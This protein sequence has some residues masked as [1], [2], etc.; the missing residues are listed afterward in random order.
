MRVSL[1]AYWQQF[2]SRIDKAAF[3]LSTETFWGKK[4]FCKIY[5]IFINFGLSTKT[6]W[7]IRRKNFC[8]IV[9]FAFFLIG[10]IF[11]GKKCFSKA[12]FFITSSGFEQKTFRLS[13]K[14]NRQCCQYGILR[15]KRKVLRMKFFLKRFILLP[16][17]A[18]ELKKSLRFRRRKICSDFKT[19][20]FVSVEQFEDFFWNFSTF[21]FVQEFRWSSSSSM[22][23]LFSSVVKTAFYVPK[24][25]FW[26][27]NF[28]E[29]FLFSHL[30]GLSEECF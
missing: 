2:L 20:F 17:S 1:C 10:G 22:A 28:F 14:T 9:K 19:A 21:S 7:D 18:F 30:F 23:K 24:A 4:R 29:V 8:I 26:W 11:R 3:Y 16:F 6:N 5:T 12:F 27:K 25:T 13:T 15:F